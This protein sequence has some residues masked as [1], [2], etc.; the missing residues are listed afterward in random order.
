MS[1]TFTVIPTTEHP[2]ALD[3]TARSVWNGPERD[4]TKRFLPSVYQ[5]R[6]GYLLTWAEP[7]PAGQVPACCSVLE[8]FATPAEAIDAWRQIST[9]A[10]S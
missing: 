1:A 5:V 10:T 4:T 2:S 6:G 9:E 7:A 3:R 8:L